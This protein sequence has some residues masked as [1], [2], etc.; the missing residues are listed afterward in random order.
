VHLVGL[1]C[2]NI[3]LII[4]IY[5]STLSSEGYDFRGGG[6]RGGGIIKNKMRVLIFSTTFV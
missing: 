2:R 4:I 3:F 1:Y 6:E 5:F